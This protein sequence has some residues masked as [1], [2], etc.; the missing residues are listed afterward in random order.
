MKNKLPS[1]SSNKSKSKLKNQV[2][3]N[4]PKVDKQHKPKKTSVKMSGVKKALSKAV[5]A[6][7][8]KAKAIAKEEKRKQKY[9]SNLAKRKPNLSKQELLRKY[10]EHQAV[11]AS[12]EHRAKIEALRKRRAE[13][14][15]KQG[16]LNQLQKFKKYVEEKQTPTLQ[17]IAWDNFNEAVNTLPPEIQ[18]HIRS[19]LDELVQ[20]FGQ[21][22]VA[23]FLNDLDLLDTRGEIFYADYG[24]QYAIL[25]VKALSL[26]LENASLGVK[27]TPDELERDLSRFALGVSEQFEGIGG[28]NNWLVSKLVSDV[29]NKLQEL[30]IRGID[31]D[32]SIAQKIEDYF[33]SIYG[34][35]Y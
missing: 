26:A 18:I 6:R 29:N 19:Q 21:E 30:T 16:E 35:N 3:V 28:A 24:V 8:K 27:L 34:D 5:K 23:T 15:A 31:Y 9:I 4:K 20:E 10:K 1:P 33:D 25:Y 12:P 11:L 17:D 2:K 7:E 13:L 32:T 22:A 14:K